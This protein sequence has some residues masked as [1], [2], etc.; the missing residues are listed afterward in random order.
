[1]SLL[2]WIPP[3]HRLH[4]RPLPEVYRELVARYLRPA[5]EVAHR[6]E[7]F[8]AAHMKGRPWV[9]AHVRGSDKITETPQLERLHAAYPQ[10]ITRLLADRPDAGVFLLTEDAV[11]AERFKVLF[12]DRL[13]TTASARTRTRIAPHFSDVSAVSR[14]SLGIEVLVDT[15]LAA[16][17]DAFI[18]M[19]SSNVSCM[20]M[21]LGQWTPRTALLLDPPLHFAT[22]FALYD[23]VEGIGAVRTPD[24]APKRAMVGI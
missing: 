7:T 1:M 19:G 20:V 8:R 2:P 13:L 17:C 22:H 6:V 15:L 12:P 24:M 21:H 4:G 23:P 9:A 16:G 11:V 5:D 3:A 18:G 10:A 14:K